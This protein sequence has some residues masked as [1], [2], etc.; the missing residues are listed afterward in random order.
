MA[1]RLKPT[2]RLSSASLSAAISERSNT[3][4]ACCADGTEASTRPLATAIWPSQ[5]RS[6]AEDWSSPFRLAKVTRARRMVFSARS[7]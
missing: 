2:L 3:R 1:R 7:V 6:G 4:R 5:S